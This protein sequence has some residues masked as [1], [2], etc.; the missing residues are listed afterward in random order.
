[1]SSADI[2]FPAAGGRAMRAAYAA[3]ADAQK[4]SGVIVIH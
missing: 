2:T 3:P 4:H 1:M